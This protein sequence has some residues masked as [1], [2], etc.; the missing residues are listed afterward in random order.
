ML[1]DRSL[2]RVRTEHLGDAREAAR[3]WRGLLVVAGSDGTLDE[4]VYGIGLAG[5]P[6]G[7]RRRPRPDTRR[8]GRPLGGRYKDH[9]VRRALRGRRGGARVRLPLSPGDNIAVGEEG[10]FVKLDG[11]SRVLLVAKPS[12]ER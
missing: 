1:G 11:E 7:Y 10:V 4:E 2:D 8:I 5:F 9:R 12:T 3:E 6:D